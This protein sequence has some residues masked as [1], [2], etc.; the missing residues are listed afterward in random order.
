MES[1]H[2]EGSWSEQKG[3]ANRLYALLIGGGAGVVVVVVVVYG[4]TW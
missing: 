4:S 2:E 1:R 3:C